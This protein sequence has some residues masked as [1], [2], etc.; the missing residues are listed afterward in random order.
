MSDTAEQSQS[1]KALLHDIDW[2]RLRYGMYWIYQQNPHHAQ[3]AVYV[4][5]RLWAIQRFAVNQLGVDE[6]E[7][8]GPT[9][10]EVGECDLCHNKGWVFC[11]NVNLS[12][13]TVERCDLCNI[14]QSDEAAGDQAR[15]EVRDG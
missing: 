5:D 10:D 14:F 13:W 6:V 12:R 1:A 4:L 15:K 3:D 7:V 9:M 2:G 11:Y 8:F